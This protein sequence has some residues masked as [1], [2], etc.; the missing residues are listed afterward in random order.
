M[1]HDL[2]MNDPMQRQPDTT[3]AREIL[4]WDAKVSRAECMKLT[5]DYFKTLSSEELLKEEHKDSTKYIH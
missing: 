4:G 1:Y 5:Y 2:P 3:K